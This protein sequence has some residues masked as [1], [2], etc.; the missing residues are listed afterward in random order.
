M[1]T[2]LIVAKLYDGFSTIKNGQRT[3]YKIVD[4]EIDKAID[5]AF[6]V[7]PQHN[8]TLV[9]HLGILTVSIFDRDWN[10]LK[11]EMLDTISV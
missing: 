2:N 4:S 11:F 7:K 5:L 6:F 1:K 10:L 8:V 9:L 3:N